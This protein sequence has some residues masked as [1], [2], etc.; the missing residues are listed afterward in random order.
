MNSLRFAQNVDRQFKTTIGRHSRGVKQAG[1]L[2]LWKS[3][4]PSVLIEAG[5]LTN[6][7]EEL[8]LNDKSGSRIWPRVSTGLS[9]IIR[10]NW[11]P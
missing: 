2:V 6:R 8:Y 4:M 7:T 1:F 10:M 5:F 3:T 11:K 9:G